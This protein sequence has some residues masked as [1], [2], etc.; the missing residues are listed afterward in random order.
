[1]FRP[2]SLSTASVTPIYSNG[3]YQVYQYED[4]VRVLTLGEPTLLGLAC[5]RRHRVLSAKLPRTT[6]TTT[7]P[8]PSTNSPTKNSNGAEGT[9]THRTTSSKSAESLWSSLPAA[10][11]SRPA[12]NGNKLQLDV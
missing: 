7:I 6:S 1:M 2:S 9:G 10:E 11:N 3:V 8:P 4:D 12:G 5:V